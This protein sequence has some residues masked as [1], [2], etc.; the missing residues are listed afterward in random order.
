MSWSGKKVERQEDRIRHTTKKCFSIIVIILQTL[1]F[2]KSFVVFAAKQ[3]L[4]N[5]QKYVLAYEVKI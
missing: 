1:L 2:V 3:Q 4:L 5:K